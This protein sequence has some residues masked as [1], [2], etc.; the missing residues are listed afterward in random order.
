MV[1]EKEIGYGL[2]REKRV[3]FVVAGGWTDVHRMPASTTDASLPL[4][5][6]RHAFQTRILPRRTPQQGNV[7]ENVHERVRRATCEFRCQLQT[8]LASS[9]PPQ[10]CIRTNMEWHRS[11]ISAQ[12]D[13]K[14]NSVRKRHAA[15]L[16]CYLITSATVRI[17]YCPSPTEIRREKFTLIDIHICLRVVLSGHSMRRQRYYCF[18]SFLFRL[19]FVSVCLMPSCSSH[20]SRQV[21]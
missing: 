18:F 6:K 4:T 21:R 2:H 19:Y 16:R 15:E 3:L 14:S 9:P 7:Q 1:D 10:N 17:M 20:F 8:I 5:Q 13:T 12:I 11:S